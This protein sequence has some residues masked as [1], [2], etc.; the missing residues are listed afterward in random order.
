M[1]ITN[2]CTTGTWFRAYGLGLSVWVIIVLF[3]IPVRNGACHDSSLPFEHQASYLQHRQVWK[4]R[5]TAKRGSISAAT[6][7]P[8]LI[9]KGF[10]CLSNRCSTQ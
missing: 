7:I 9:P 4:L 8:T 1:Q 6:L 5:F 10:Q 3:E 2:E